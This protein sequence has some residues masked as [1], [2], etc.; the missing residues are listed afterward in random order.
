MRWLP[1]CL[2]ALAAGC[3]SLNHY[4]KWPSR[5]PMLEVR[6]PTALRRVVIARDG[7]GRMLVKASIQPNDRACFRWPFIDGRGELLAAGADT[8]SSG[9]FEPW[10]ADGWAWAMDGPPLAAPDACR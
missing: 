10:S 6:N 9:P 1:L 3:G 5:G 4:A 8:V 2:I 7:A